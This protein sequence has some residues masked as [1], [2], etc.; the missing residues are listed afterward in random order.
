MAEVYH[1]FNSVY[2]EDILDGKETTFEEFGLKVNVLYLTSEQ[3]RRN[4]QF[5]NEFPAHVS[6]FGKHLNWTVIR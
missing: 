2:P 4:M 6:L 1:S 5:V 3:I